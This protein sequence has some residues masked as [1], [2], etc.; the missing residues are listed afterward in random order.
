MNHSQSQAENPGVPEFFI[1]FSAK[2]F[3][4]YTKNFGLEMVWQNLT[5]GRYY[6]GSSWLHGLDPRTKLILGLTV[7]ACLMWAEQWLA[8]GFW[9]VVLAGVIFSSRVPPR[10]F[11]KNVRAFAWLFAITIVIHAL[12]D[13]TAPHLQVWGISIS[14]PGCAAG[15]KYALRLA[16][17]ILVAALLSFTS[18]PVDLAEGMERL[19]RPLRRLR[20]PVHE[21]AFMT[22]LALRFVPT[23]VE[24]AQR[25]QRAQMSRGA[26][27]EGSL[28]QR[29]QALVPMLVP[30]FVATFNRADELAVA[31][32]ARGYES[33]AER[34]AYREMRLHRRDALALLGAA[35]AGVL[36]VALNRVEG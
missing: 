34:V 9:I 7:M 30:L 14:W 8:L 27:F 11:A 33:G 29:L 17:L 4:I 20:A 23:I 21:M 2:T 28:A 36:T 12:S 3:Y 16:L 32:A 25:I 10:F 13:P 5:L 1:C 18:I 35:V 15:G 19:L 26:R 31:L 22:S 24:E 6:P